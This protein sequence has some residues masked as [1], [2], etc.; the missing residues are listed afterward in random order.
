MSRALLKKT[1][2][3]P[4]F[5]CFKFDV[6]QVDLT[7]VVPSSETKGKQPSKQSSQSEV[8]SGQVET[9]QAGQQQ[10]ET[11]PHKTLAQQLQ[12]TQQQLAQQQQLQLQAAQQLQ[13]QQLQLAQQHALQSE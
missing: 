9:K 12:E 6:L 10:Q 1:Y 4:V 8:K 2:S 3:Q 13:A 5:S 11:K 7:N